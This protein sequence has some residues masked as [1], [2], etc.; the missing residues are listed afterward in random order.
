MRRGFTLIELIISTAIIMMILTT[1]LPAFVRFQRDQ[2]L[3]T[4]AQKVRD[5]IYQA[6]NYALAPRVEK[7]G[8]GDYY[9]IYFYNEQ[10]DNPTDAGYDIQ[11]LQV[12]TVNGTEINTWQTVQS[13]RLP[14]FVVICSVS[15]SP[16]IPTKSPIANN[17]IQYSI[18]QLGHIIEPHTV[19]TF[20][21]RLW[22]TRI[23]RYRDVTIN[24]QTGQVQLIDSPADGANGQPECTI[25]S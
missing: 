10:T 3:L 5:A 25:P 7:I 19:D 20:F 8:N 1:M 13:G 22:Q 18:T 12:T 16:L 14:R 15:S 24:A 6:Q 17:T 21:V 4:A 2:D 23:N 11:E 9:R